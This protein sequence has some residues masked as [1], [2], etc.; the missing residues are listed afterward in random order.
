M[1]SYGVANGSV[2]WQSISPGIPG[3]YNSYLDSTNVASPTYSPGP[4]APPYVD[5]LVCGMPIATMCGYTNTVCDTVRIYNFS[6]LTAS[7]T[8]NPASFCNTGLGS[9]VIMGVSV[10]GGQSPYS[11]IWTSGTGTVATTNSYFAT[12]TGTYSVEVRDM[13]YNSN[14]CPA[15]IQTVAVNQGTVPVVNA[16]TDQTVCATS[17]SILL[18]GN[19][20]FAGGGMWSGGGGSFSPS[21]A[22]LNPTYVPS[23]SE[24]AAGYVT[25]NLTS[26]A[27]GASCPNQT[28]AVTIYFYNLSGSAMVASSY[29]GA[30]ISCAGLSDGSAAAS[31]IGGVGPFTYTWNTVPVQNSATANNLS[32]GTYVVMMADANNC[33]ASANVTLVDPPMLVASAALTQSVSCFGGSDG[34]A[35]VTESGGIP[36]Y[37]YFWNTTPAQ[38]TSNATGLSAGTYSVIVVDANGC[39]ATANITL[40]AAAALNAIAS[41]A[42]SYSGQDISCFGMT[43]GV[44][45][46]NVTGGAGGYTYSWNTLPVQNTM[47]AINLGAGTYV[48][49]ITDANSCTGTATVTLNE[50][51]PLLPMAV[52]QS[53]SCSGGNN[54]SATITQSGGTPGYSY[55]WSTTPVQTGAMATGLSAGN[56][57]VIVS[58]ANGCQAMSLVNVAE[59]SPVLVNINSLSYYNGYHISCHGSNDGNVDISV[60]GGVGGYSYSWSNGSNTEDIS[61][62]GAGAYNVVVT[63]ANGCTNTLNVSLIEPSKLS[64]GIES[65]SLY[66][67]YNISCNGYKDGAIFVAVNGGTGNYSYSWNTGD[68]TQDLT[69]VGAGV[70]SLN[71]MDQNGCITTVNATLVEP[72]PILASYTTQKPSCNGLQ[73][74][75]IHLLAGGGTSPYSYTWSN[76]VSSSDN[77]NLGAGAY[78]VVTTDMNGCSSQHVI[79]LS[80]PDV[81]MIDKITQ[82]LKCYMDSTGEVACLPVGGTAPYEYNWSTGDATQ[83]ISALLAGTY[84]VNVTDANGCAASETVEV[85]Q[86]ELLKVSLTSPTQFNGFNVSMHNGSDGSIETIVTGGNPPFNFNWSNNSTIEDPLN[87]GS[88]TFTVLCTDANG[89]RTAGNITLTAPLDLEM[90]TGFSPNADGS[91]DLFVV[92]GIEAYPSNYLTVF[93]RWGNIVYSTAMYNNSWN[94]NNSEGEALPDATYFVLLEINGQEKVLKGYVE[95]RR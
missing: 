69:G 10:S 4:G 41:V 43:D 58:D 14:T 66:D 56:Y 61:G 32:A 77:L 12:A 83:T 46:V 17:S 20:Q 22:A 37:T 75:A 25:L 40:N 53:V 51:P 26:T 34:S 38:T 23:A 7:V 72:S 54:G 15:A 87:L 84:M 5:Y 70:Y 92:H 94:G 91:N 81:L 33:M 88:G 31:P 24:I 68:N 44:A 64:A 57:N 62:V 11:Y 45:S 6:S 2:T 27:A 35:S 85:R 93:N 60:N 13:L 36:G 89:C 59:P 39:K 42:S 65:L 21:S 49:T 67:V 50:P 3:Q 19:V 52:S 90:P 74:G 95:I 78:T 8:P 48:V 71:V 73:D 55:Q 16:G 18:N 1:I 86:P 9:G 82:H 28:D 47:S 79:K 63:D 29:N 30:D 80:E 76:G